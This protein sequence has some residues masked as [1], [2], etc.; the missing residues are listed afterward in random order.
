[1]ACRRHL[2][3][4]QEQV[5]AVLRAQAARIGGPRQASRT[6]PPGSRRPAAPR[7]GGRPARRGWALVRLGEQRLDL[8]VGRGGDPR[9]DRVGLVV[10]CLDTL[11]VEDRDT[12]QTSQLTREP[13]VDDGVH[14]RRQHR[15]AQ[16]QASEVDRGVHLRGLDGLDAGRQR[17]VI[18][19][20]GRADG[21]DARC[22]SGTSGRSPARDS[23]VVTGTVDRPSLMPRR[24]TARRWRVTGRARTPRSGEYTGVTTGID[25][26]YPEPP[27]EVTLVE[28]RRRRGVPRPGLRASRSGRRCCR[29]ADP[30]TGTRRVTRVSG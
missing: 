8:V 12:T 10:A 20:V 18:E 24:R 9:Q 15:D 29:S 23:C 17:D 14:G 1:M 7:C 11:Q 21:V 3:L 16:V 6:R 5:R 28:P 27:T 13:D 2:R 26:T 30:S 4:D 25:Q 19:A 22:A